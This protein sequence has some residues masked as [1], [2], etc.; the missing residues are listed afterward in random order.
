MIFLKF[1]F[2]RIIAY[3]IVLAFAMQLCEST[4]YIPFLL[5]LP[6]HLPL[7]SPSRLSQSTRLNSLCYIY[8]NFPLAV[9][10]TY[11]NVYISITFS[12]CPTFSF[13]CCIQNLFSVSASLSLP[14][15]LGLLLKKKFFFLSEKG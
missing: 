6:H 8:S 10:F 9:Y 11:G 15:K 2:K 1:I 12:I 4:I 7:P 13:P 3:N 5:N 14:C